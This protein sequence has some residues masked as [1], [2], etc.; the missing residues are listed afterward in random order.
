MTRGEQIRPQWTHESYMRVY[1]FSSAERYMISK[2]SEKPT[3]AAA[4]D[5]LFR[6]NPRRWHQVVAA[7][8]MARR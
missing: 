5:G 6:R 7:A 2:L 3:L 4:L 8:V 1:E